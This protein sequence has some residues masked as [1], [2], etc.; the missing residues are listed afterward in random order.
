MYKS[1]LFTILILTLLMPLT[2]ALTPSYVS[3]RYNDNN[4]IAE[5][6][7]SPDPFDT[8]VN[9]SPEGY[10]KFNSY[11]EDITFQVARIYEVRSKVDYLHTRL[12]EIE[13]ERKYW[14][15]G[16]VQDEISMDLIIGVLR[17]IPKGDRF[18]SGNCGAYRR[19][20]FLDFDPT[21]SFQG[22]PKDPSVNRAFQIFKKICVEKSVEI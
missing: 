17:E 12:D 7:E 6:V 15:R 11:I 4:D 19:R 20:I 8:V 5:E 18:H 1:K 2:L 13:K 14:D 3:E 21:S 9:T 10:R 16:R 22:E